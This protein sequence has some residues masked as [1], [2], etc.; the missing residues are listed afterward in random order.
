MIK[1]LCIVAV[2]AI[3]LLPVAA[4]AVATT[5]AECVSTN[6]TDLGAGPMTPTGTRLPPEQVKA[7]RVRRKCLR[8]GIKFIRLAG[9][10]ASDPIKQGRKR[11]A[12]LW[13]AARP[14]Q[15]VLMRTI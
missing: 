13:L 14:D 9:M 6:W 1:M 2:A 12:H 10:L 11:L 5:A 7:A 3:A 8:E 15:D 4:Y